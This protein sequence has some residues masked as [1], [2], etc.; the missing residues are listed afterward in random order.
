VELGVGHALDLV[1]WNLSREVPYLYREL[2]VV[3]SKE[4]LIDMEYQRWV[5][6][7]TIQDETTLKESM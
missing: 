7:V 4:P 2:A 1:F 6:R 3:V 5:P